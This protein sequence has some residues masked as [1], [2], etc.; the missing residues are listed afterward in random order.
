MAENRLFLSFIVKKSC[1]MC[2]N[3]LVMRFD[4]SVSENLRV[5]SFREATE[6]ER[7]VI[8]NHSYD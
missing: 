3:L 4:G 8:L 2:L 1:F 6:T 7:L 5:S